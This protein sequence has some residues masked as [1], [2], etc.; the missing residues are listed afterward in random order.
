MT[1]IDAM[2]FLSLLAVISM[3]VASA[4]MSKALLAALS[5]RDKDGF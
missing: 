2:V 4:M 3:S 5:R 1:S